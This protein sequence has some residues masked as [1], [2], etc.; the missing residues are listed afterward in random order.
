MSLELILTYPLSAFTVP[1]ITFSNEL[2]PEPFNPEMQ[3]NPES[4]ISTFKEKSPL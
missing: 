1:A 3:M 2:F 4:W